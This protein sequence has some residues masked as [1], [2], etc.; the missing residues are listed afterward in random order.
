MSSR[1]PETVRHAGPAR[2]AG[3][4]LPLGPSAHYASRM[5]PLA[6]KNAERK[7]DPVLCAV[8]LGGLSRDQIGRV[9]FAALRRL[10]RVPLAIRTLFTRLP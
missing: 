10:A 2:G 6:L 1:N 5:A 8:T 7:M 4:G 3:T 9:D